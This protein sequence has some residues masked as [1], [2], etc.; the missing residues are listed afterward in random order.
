VANAPGSMLISN[1]TVSA[2]GSAHN[3]LF[4]NNAGSVTPLHILNGFDLSIGGTLTVTNSVLQVDANFGVSGVDT[5]LIDGSVDLQTDG[6]IVAVSE[7]VGWTQTGVLNLSGGSNFTYRVDIGVFNGSTGTVSVTDGILEVP[8]TNNS[9]IG[10]FIGHG[11]VGSL[12]QSGG[13]VDTVL[14]DVGDTSAGTLTVAGG[15]HIVENSELS[16]GFGGPYGVTGTVWVTGGQ[17]LANGGIAIGNIA[18]SAGFLTQSNGVVQTIQ[19]IVGTPAQGT[20]TIAGGTHVVGYNGLDVGDFPL[21]P[22][23]GT[24]TVWLTGGQLVTTNSEFGTLSGA[25]IG[26]YGVGRMTVSNGIWQASSVF[27]GANNGSEGTLT[28]AG[29]TSSAYSNMTVGDCASNAVGFVFVEGGDLFVTNATHDAVLDLRNGFVA[30]TA[31]QLVV[32]K[33]VMTNACGFFFHGGGKLVYSQVE[34]DPNLSAV[35]DGIPNGWKLQYGLDPFDANL[36]NEDPDGDGVNNLDEYL[37]G[38]NPTDPHDPFRIT[39]AATKSNNFR[40]TWQ[41]VPPPYG[42]L[43]NCIVEASAAVTG[44]WNA[45]SGTITLPSGPLTIVSTNYLDGGGATNRPARFYRVRFVP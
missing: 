8:Y 41:Y 16:V 37:L 38:T 10:I 43:S 19:E 17:L 7:A 45:V 34:L 36:A 18:G 33:L 28:V 32:D 9:S 42:T 39:A 29:G 4:L 5:F 13:T 23:L 6:S 26:E 44:T 31:G 21:S 2:P 12:I 25:L 30:L 15:T 1:L 40:V 11:G 35:A 24:G 14:E 27:V 22:Y 20:L 3:I